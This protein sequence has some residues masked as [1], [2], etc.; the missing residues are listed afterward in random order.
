MVKI[1][2]FM[3][4]ES[5]LSL[6][7]KSHLRLVIKVP[8]RD[9]EY[10]HG[11]TAKTIRRRQMLATRVLHNSAPLASRGITIQSHNVSTDTKT[12]HV[13]LYYSGG[14]EMPLD[15]ISRSLLAGNERLSFE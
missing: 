14:V 5:S 3:S 15:E 2:I 13:D 8:E 4:S 1:D 9:S 7:G 10:H 12:L 11:D 6:N